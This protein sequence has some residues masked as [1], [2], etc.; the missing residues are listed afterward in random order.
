[1]RQAMSGPALRYSFTHECGVVGLAADTGS[2]S[3]E[4]RTARDRFRRQA[5]AAG[6][7]RWSLA[8]DVRGPDGGELGLDLAWLGPAA[9]PRW[10]VVQSGV[11]GVEA[12]AGAAVQL[13]LLRRVNE[14]NVDLNRNCL[15]A[16][17]RYTGAPPGYRELDPLL[18]PSSA[19][20]FDFFT[21]R[22]GWQIVRHGLGSLKQAVV[23]GQYEYPRGLFYGGSQL[24]QGPLLLRDWLDSVRGPLRALVVL[25]LHSGLGRYGKASVFAEHI[26]G[27]DAEQLLRRR[28]GAVTPSTGTFGHGYRI[29]GGVAN[30]YR[31]LF[32]GIE[33]H[34]L[35]V[36]FGTYSMLRVL[37]ALR[38]ENRWHFYGEG[39]TEHASKAALRQALGPPDERWRRGVLQHGRRLTLLAVGDR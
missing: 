36:E 10:V 17:E 7:R 31:Q 9:A 21:L 16:G 39:G 24:E 6:A 25:D 19:P 13:D 33:Y 23:A 14:N 32:P 27:R 12:F 26:A 4:Y 38:Q 8:L 34:Y 15:G 1:M 3:P 5:D 30:L 35:T 22:A 28:F 37:H 20:V 18:N 11:H 2:F 29:R